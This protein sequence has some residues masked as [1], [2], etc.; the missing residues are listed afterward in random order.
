[1]ATAYGNWTTGLRIVIEYSQTKDI[2]NNR[3]VVSANYY[4]E[5]ANGYAWYNVDWHDAYWQID[6]ANGEWDWKPFD[7]RNYSKLFLK[8]KTYTVNHKGDGTANIYFYTD[9][10]TGLQDYGCSAHIY[11]SGSVALE[12]IDRSAPEV[13]VQITDITTNALTIN[14]STNVNCDIWEYSLT[15]GG[16]WVQFSTTVGTSA[17]VTVSGL[18]IN[19]NYIIQVRARKT[20][21]LVYGTSASQNVKTLGG[22][23]Y[24]SDGNSA[25]KAVSYASDGTGY[26]AAIAYI[27][28]LDGWKMTEY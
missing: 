24:A 5:I 13:T 11:F 28:T 20:A 12:P 16:S 19:T 26:K 22:A 14:A 9:F 27:Y 10:Y 21:N 7:F 1:M 2:T 25:K 8:S 3:S 18:Q 17:S 4:L 15:N 23:V 6:S